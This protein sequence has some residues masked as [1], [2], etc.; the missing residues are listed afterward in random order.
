MGPWM[1]ILSH[2]GIGGTSLDVNSNSSSVG[3]GRREG[4]SDRLWATAYWRYCSGCQARYI[5]AGPEGRNRRRHGRRSLFLGAKTKA[6]DEDMMR[7][8]PCRGLLWAQDNADGNCHGC[9]RC[10]SEHLR[11]QARTCGTD[12]GQRRFVR[13]RSEFEFVCRWMRLR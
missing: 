7:S 9:R 4:G 13:M 1:A 11:A 8:R 3:G 10:L 2:A 5:A 12:L 6:R